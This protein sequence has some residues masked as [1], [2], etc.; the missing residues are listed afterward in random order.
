MV[1]QDD[2]PD[3]IR[4]TDQMV[5]YGISPSVHSYNNIIDAIVESMFFFLDYNL[6]FLYFF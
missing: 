1:G 4:V 5:H 6:R 2:I 3:A